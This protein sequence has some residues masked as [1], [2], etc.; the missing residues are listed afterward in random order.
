[1]NTREVFQFNELSLLF[2]PDNDILCKNNV[3]WN[4]DN[5][6]SGGLE[7]KPIC[8]QYRIEYGIG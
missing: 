1:M 7:F 5:T 4:T 6:L 3:C 8:V 2:I